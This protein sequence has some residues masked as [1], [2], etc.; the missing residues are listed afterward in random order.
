MIS[1]A[2]ARE[3]QE[4]L[5]SDLK[6]L[7]EIESP[8]SD[9]SSVD[10]LA[11]FLASR[12]EYHGGHAQ[13]H[14]AEGFGN[15]VQADFPGVS[16]SKPI[17]LLGHI[18]T[19]W[20]LGTLK[21]MPFRVADGRAWG[22]G[23]LDMKGGI[24]V[25]IHA[26]A[27]LRE[28]KVPHAAVRMLFVSDEEVGS[29]SSRAITE[30]LALE[31]QA[32]LVLEPGQGLNGA[33][34][35]ERKGVGVYEIR[36]TGEAAHAG[37]EPGKGASAIHELAYQVGVLDGF[38]DPHRGLTVNA[39]LIRGGTRSNVIAA[40]AWAEVDVRI[41]TAADGRAIDSKVRGLRPRNDR[42]RIEV[43]GGINRPPMERTDKVVALYRKAAE[44]GR[45]LGLKIDEL[46][47]GGG[48]DGNF[49]AALGVPTL[50]GLGVVGEGAHAVNESIL[51]DQLAPRTA[52]LAGLIAAL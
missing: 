41:R 2:D 33:V 26:M 24:A 25:A 39:G 18:D 46:P 28:H 37:V 7:V 49:T 20:E 12:L 47:T 42:C 35:T 23:V 43:T 19:V 30:R 9:K 11:E 14:I 13:I 40:E 6:A 48:S 52:L 51:I 4:V 29:H 32:V 34:K 8:S 27:L 21:Q 10:H 22:P 5:L 15:H 38:T 16:E 36:V 44:V 1:V 31:S 45:S 50:D 17:L 3:H